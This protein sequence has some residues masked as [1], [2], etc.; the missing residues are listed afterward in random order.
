M[1]K[2]KNLIEM[3]TELVQKYRNILRKFEREI[4]F[5]NVASCCHGVSLPQCHALLEVEG[6]ENISLTELSDKLTLE[7]STVSRTVDGLVKK[8]YLN[9]KIPEENRRTVK[10]QLTQAGEKT[11]EN[12]NW[13]NNH[14][15]SEV[16]N[17]LDE[18]DQASFVHLFEKITNKMTQIRQS[19]KCC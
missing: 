6:Q 17:T 13:N 18:N 3:K 14:F 5:Q 15:I 12:I 2:L 16:L 8:G 10:L 9:R 11:C 1:D 7:K 4:F 19:G